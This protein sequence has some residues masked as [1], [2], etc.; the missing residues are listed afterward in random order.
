MKTLYHGTSAAFID[1]IMRDGI[2]PRLD[3]GGSNWEHTVESRADAV[4][5]T[6]AYPFYFAEQACKNDEDLAIIELGN[7]NR[8]FLI[9]DEDVLAQVGTK[10]HR[11]WRE[12][13]LFERTRKYREV[14]HRYSGEA[15][16]DLMGTCAHL[17]MIPPHAIT[18]IAIIPRKEVCG[19]IMAVFD[20]FIT[21][22]NYQL[23]GAQYDDSAQWLFGDIP[24][25]ELN[26][27]AILPD[28]IQ[29]IMANQ[30]QL[31]EKY[32]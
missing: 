12:L 7:I 21:V 30:Y 27:R 9:A 20:P 10:E 11:Q 26:E 23:L 15:T 29:I 31:K 17:G 5:L 8:S 1:A 28:G 25:C 4:Y 32:A 19:L 18:R 13:T 6:S 2:R 14:S 16:L 22:N 3:T 24:V